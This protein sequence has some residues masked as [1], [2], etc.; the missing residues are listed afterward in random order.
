MSSPKHQSSINDFDISPIECSA[1]IVDSSRVAMATIAVL[2]F[3][4]HSHR[5]V[6]QYQNN[7]SF[8]QAM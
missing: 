5:H 8:Q 1:T 4:I 7:A 3:G 6:T 2:K